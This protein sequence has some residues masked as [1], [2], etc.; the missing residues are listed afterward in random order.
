MLISACADYRSL[1]FPDVEVEGLTSTF[2]GGLQCEV[3][4]LESGSSGCSDWQCHSFNTSIDITTP[5]CEIRSF[6]LTAGCSKQLDAVSC[7]IE[8]LWGIGCDN[9]A[10]GTDKTRLVFMYGEL[11][12]DLR[13]ASQNGTNPTEVDTEKTTTIVCE[14]KYNITDT[15]IIMDRHGNLKNN[16]QKTATST[17]TQ[18]FPAYDLV[19]GLLT[20]CDAA[21]VVLGGDYSY[22]VWSSKP[23]DNVLTLFNKWVAAAYPSSNL[24]D[25]NVL[26]SRANEMFAMVTA[27]MVKQNLMRPSTDTTIGT[28]RATEDRLRVRGLSLYLMGAV[29]VLL[30]LST[31]TL[32][33]IAP[34]T[35]SSRD[36]SSIGGL[37]LVV[38]QSPS[39]LS[40]LSSSGSTDLKTMKGQMDNVECQTLLTQKGHAW[41]FAI[42]LS[43]TN[44]SEEQHTT[45]DTE[46]KSE[47]TYWRPM[48]LR[49]VFKILV[50]VALLI[51]VVL[52]EVLYSV[53]QKNDGLT[54]VEPHQNQRFAWVYIPAIIMIA[55]QTLV[56]MIA[57]SSLLIFPYFQLRSGKPNTRRDIL[58]NYASE[59]AIKS[60][61]K[62]VAAKHIIVACM[63]LAMLLAPLLTIAVSGLYTAQATSGQI[64]VTLSVQDQL[65]SS[66]TPLHLGSTNSSNSAL[67]ANNI[68]LLLS[69]N[70]TFPRWTYDELAFPEM[71][72]EIPPTV[73]LSTLAGSNITATLPA[74]RSD[75]SC[76]VAAVVPT[77]FTDVLGDR[78]R[79]ANVSAFEAL[80]V[81][82]GEY[83][84]P[85]WP[86]PESGKPFGLFSECGERAYNDKTN[87]FCGVLGTSELH[88]NAFTCFS[89]INQ[90]DVEV[91][92]DASTL[93]II[94]A[95]PD[96]STVRF[97]SNQTLTRGDS[98]TFPSSMIPALF[99]SSNF[100]IDVAGYYDPTFQ[101]VVYGLGTHD[102]LDNFPMG[103]YMSNEGFEKIVAQLQ[104][105]HRTVTAQSADFIRIPLDTSSP[106]APPASVN[107]MLINPNIYRLHQSA[108]STRILDGLLI[109]IALC[110]ALSFFLMDTRK[111]LPKNPASIAAGASLIAGDARMIR[112]D[113]LPEG[114][115]WYSDTELNAKKVWD[116]LFFRLGWWDN[117]GPSENGGQGKYFKIDTI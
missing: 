36:P 102:S 15:H 27:Q 10:D 41:Q 1:G 45:P 84:N 62:S 104:H 112:S 95:T 89:T 81:Y 30:M 90:L 92:M 111:V 80:G 108:V 74:I 54:E 6:N 83:G 58:Q 35:Y 56:G 55:A 20:A 5:T 32:L 37:A 77:N 49:P 106:L 114:A 8:D 12:Q 116:G 42:D 9:Y 76:S 47:P 17:H 105:I 97:F 85:Y 40:R 26:Q 101:A 34:R 60:L 13:K 109:A 50:I 70:F 98:D 96:E 19:D 110:V 33:C 7:P 16:P 3:A 63:A 18:R 107:A 99:G 23:W 75:L 2:Y 11:K 39:L 21:G 61:W 78:Q 31:L 82:S 103:E 69:Q 65:N 87:T 46:P 57:F 91:I 71:I 66:F 86:I 113:I 4:T 59:T 64:S 94:A 44:T 22:W 38:S 52:L 53:S 29:L 93:A 24:K 117:D 100:R 14:A 73:N 68:G 43:S 72:L 25:P 28:C 48:S 115:Q 88:W 67:S 51:L 79:K